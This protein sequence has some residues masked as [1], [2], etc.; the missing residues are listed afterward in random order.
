[1]TSTS[2]G[3]ICVR[4]NEDYAV[5]V[6]ELALQRSPSYIMLLGEG[7]NLSELIKQGG[8]KAN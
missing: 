3:N 2:T 6:T 8:P 5:A 7:V 4:G 1:M